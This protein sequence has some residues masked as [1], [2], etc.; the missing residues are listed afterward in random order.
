MNPSTAAAASKPSWKNQ[1]E[2]FLLISVR[3]IADHQ[4]RF[5]TAVGAVALTLVVVVFTINQRAK[6]QEDAW[7]Q[8]GIAQGQLFQGNT[9]DAIASLDSWEARFSGSRAADYARFMRADLLAKTTQYAEAAAIYADLAARA[10]PDVLRP[11]AL[12]A[13]VTAEDLAGR[14]AEAQAAAQRFMDTYPDHYMAAPILFEQARLAD[15]T[16]DAAAAAA[17]YDRITVLYP[18]SPWAELAKRRQQARSEPAH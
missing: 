8:L 3:W 6:M 11:L 12:A 5:W 4:E 10:Q 9:K 18:Q 17:L 13:Q 1:A 16:R 2:K 15:K 14:T 7:T